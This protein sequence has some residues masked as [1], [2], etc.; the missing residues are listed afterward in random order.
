MIEIDH[1]A[2]PVGHDSRLR[3]HESGEEPIAD[4]SD[5]PEST[6]FGATWWTDAVRDFE[7]HD[8]GDA[9]ADVYDSWYSDI[10]DVDATVEF[11]RR[12]VKEGSALELGIGTGRL[13]IPL[14]ASGVSVIGI[15]VSEAML[16]RLHEKN[17]S[18]SIRSIRGDMVDDLPE[19]PFDLVFVA[20]NTF[21]NVHDP[22]RQ[23]RLL[24][25]VAERLDQNGAFVIEA[26]VP[27]VDRPGGDSVGIRSMTTDSVVLR[28]DRHDPD[29]Q[30]I[31]GQ[32][33]EIT[34][35]GG[36][37]LRPYRLRYATPDQLDAMAADAGLVL[38]ERWEDTHRHTF[39]AESP[40]HVSVYRRSRSRILDSQ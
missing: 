9:I 6:R 31:D 28:A 39:D 22:E 19:G 4:P 27:D 35:T 38:T 30:T 29:A 40:T 24:E 33:V 2:R 11:L 20:Y 10:T 17:Q 34:E 5:H 25:R 8:Y 7:D 23:R 12:F 37:R 36:V 14:A 1:V 15:D 26:Y 13:A 18:Q 32:L 3:G 21:F 16:Q